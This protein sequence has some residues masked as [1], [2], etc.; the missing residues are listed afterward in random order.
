MTENT[1]FVGFGGKVGIALTSFIDKC[2]FFSVN[3]RIK[4]RKRIRKY[5]ESLCIGIYSPPAYITARFSGWQCSRFFS[6]GTK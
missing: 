4:M 2:H 5:S 1:K 3:G 6:K